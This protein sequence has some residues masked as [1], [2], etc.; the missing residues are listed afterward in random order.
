MYDFFSV[1]ISRNPSLSNNSILVGDE[2]SAALGLNDG[3]TIFLFVGKIYSSLKIYL[4]PGNFIELSSANFRKYHLTSSR[5]YG[6]NVDSDG[7][8]IGPVIGI[9]AESSK[10]A[11]RP[12]SGQS[13][14]ISQLITE[15]NQ[16]GEIC[17]AFNIESIN[18]KSK[19]IYGYTYGK[20]GWKKG[21]FPIPDVIYPRAG[22]FNSS[23]LRF[24]NN[25][26]K[27]GCK[28]INP[29][30]IGKWKTHQILS[31]NP[32]VKP[33]LP[34]TRLLKNFQMLDSMVKKYGSVYMKP[35]AGSQGR[36]IIKVIKKKNSSLYEYQYQ[37]NSKPRQGITSSVSTLRKVLKDVMPKQG[38]IVQKRINLLAVND[39]LVDIRVMV[40]KDHSGQWSVT[41]KAC[42]IGRKGSITSNIS[43]GG[44]GRKVSAVLAEKFHD[45][46]TRERIMNEIDSLGLLVA[47]SLEATTTS[48][49]ELGIDIGV[50]N[51]GCIWFIEANLKPARHVFIMI[52]ENNTRIKSVQ[53]PMLYARY[54]AGF[55]QER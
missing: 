7:I 22:A 54:L 21:V 29:P 55:S 41:G 42:R 28:F 12:F 24:R 26:L 6:I 30:I 17:F 39:Q 51:D 40:Q 31:Q 43:G 14:F 53:K 10:E 46:E 8:H 35:I 25:L 4:K 37:H 23:R 19:T 18:F 2:V 49:G 45:P 13:L 11:N 34:D 1:L 16:L 48:I 38:Y 47:E 44:C 50:D 52:G 15:G 36:N 20:G 5:R 32:F 3:D 27:M 9:M 33:Y